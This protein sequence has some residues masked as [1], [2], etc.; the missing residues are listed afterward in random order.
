MSRTAFVMVVL[1]IVSGGVAAYG[2]FFDRSLDSIWLTVAGL[3]LLGL[4]LG[5][6]AIRLGSEGVRAGWAGRGGRS[7]GLALLGGLFA[8][9]ASG[10]LGA[11]VILGLVARPI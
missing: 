1:L 5:V 10:S 9:A 4:V 7:I 3:A 6:I 11:A 2:L 8:L